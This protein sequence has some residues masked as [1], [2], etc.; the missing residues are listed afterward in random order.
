MKKITILLFG[1]AAGLYLFT[2]CENDGFYYRDEARIRMEGPYKWTVGT[3]SLEFSFITS[4]P[5][6]N[7]ISMDITLYVMGEAADH[8]RRANITIEGDKTTA[9]N[10]QYTCPSEVIIP[11]GAY[12]ATFPVVLKRTTDLQNTTVRLY[13]KVEDSEDFKV[14]VREWDHLLIKWNDILTMPKN[15]SDL[16]EFFGAFS[17][18]KYRFIINVT[19]V[20]EFNTSTMSWSQLM[21]YKIIVKNALDEYNAAH[22]D[23]PLKD[24]NGQFVTF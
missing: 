24:E 23:N 9:G 21:N 14:G 8:E 12:S 15:W 3:D 10:T 2:G 18:V 6:V 1:L 16:T 17:M 20:T 5:S 11:S 13:L 22:P 4:P 19:G 7:E